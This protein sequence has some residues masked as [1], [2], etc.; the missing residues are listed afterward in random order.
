MTGKKNKNL[1]KIILKEGDETITD[2]H[3]IANIFNDYF[4]NIAS[5]IGFSDDITSVRD[6]IIDHQN[7]PSIS[8][9][10]EKYAKK[11]DDFDFKSVNE[12]LTYMV[13]LSF[14]TATLADDLKNAELSPFTK[15][16]IT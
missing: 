11:D 7:H 1:G 12:E 5:N 15:R 13:N 9:I 16:K 8:K 10:R 6:A 3:Q 14:R 2:N 4:S